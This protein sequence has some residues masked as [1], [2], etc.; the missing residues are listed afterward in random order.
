MGGGGGAFAG[1]QAKGTPAAQDSL[2]DQRQTPFVTSAT[3]IVDGKNVFD[4]SRGVA[5]VASAANVG[6]MFRYRINHPVTVSRQQSAMLPIVNEKVEGQKLSIYNSAVQGKHPLNGLKLINTTS[7]H[8]MQGPITVYDDGTYAGDAQIADMAPQAER[9]ISYALDLDVE[10]SPS[11]GQKPQ[12]MS[13]IKIVGGALHATTRYTRFQEYKIKSSSKKARKLLIERPI[14]P[15]WK[16]VAPKEPSEKSRSM[17]RFAV[18]VPAGKTAELRVEEEHIEQ[19]QWVIVHQG[20]QFLVG[21]ASNKDIDPKVKAALQEIVRRR[22]AIAQLD[23]KVQELER[24]LQVVNVEQA[25]IRQNM[26]QL[27][28][29]NQVY[30]DYVKKLSE[31]EKTVDQVRGQIEE[32]REQRV[33]SQAEMEK[34]V[35]GLDLG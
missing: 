9:L 8:L 3:P 33:K 28:H 31:Q 4:P 21:I 14:D 27:D 7:L 18:D 26:A 13:S 35:S 19:P 5:S 12:V 29:N 1:R 24:R 22:Q 32:I 16:L 17:Y 10:V 2:G 20:D 30:V 15:S 23:A 11:G 25:R 6:E 34:Y